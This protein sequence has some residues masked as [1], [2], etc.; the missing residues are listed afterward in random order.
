MELSNKE[1][2]VGQEKLTAAEYRHCAHVA[3][4]ETEAQRD[5]VP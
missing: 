1:E 3:D 4:E 2:K 5:V